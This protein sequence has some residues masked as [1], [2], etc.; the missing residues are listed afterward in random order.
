M[1]RMQISTLK[2]KYHI[3]LIFLTGSYG[4]TR[5]I[6]PK[7]EFIVTTSRSHSDRL[8]TETVEACQPT[9]V[10]RVGGAGHKVTL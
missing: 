6:L 8:V 2:Q 4:F 3:I 9:S 1:G 5:D 7:D 10:V